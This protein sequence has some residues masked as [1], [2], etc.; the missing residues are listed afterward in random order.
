[1]RREVAE[2]QEKCSHEVIASAEERNDLQRALQEQ[3]QSAREQLDI[4]NRL[5]NS[6][7]ARLKSKDI[8]LQ[9]SQAELQRIRSAI[10]DV[11]PCKE[12]T[13]A[14]LAISG[15][16][17]DEVPPLGHQQLMERLNQQRL[18]SG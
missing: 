10:S 6:L 13:S 8:M 2:L 1:M 7:Q 12:P 5:V 14:E 4:L 3:E 11:N 9:E 17:Q 15:Q 16:S 18:E